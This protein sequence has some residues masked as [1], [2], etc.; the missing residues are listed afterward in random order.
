M[1]FVIYEPISL[2]FVTIAYKPPLCQLWDLVTSKLQS[3]G[4]N[5]TKEIMSEIRAN[6]TKLI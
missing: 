4:S 2:F 1:R 3:T 6:N 5:E